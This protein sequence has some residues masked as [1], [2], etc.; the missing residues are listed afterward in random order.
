MY[1]FIEN[2]VLVISY[3]TPRCNYCYC[4]LVSNI[5]WDSEVYGSEIDNR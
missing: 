2:L 4:Y 5:L 1:C 3:S